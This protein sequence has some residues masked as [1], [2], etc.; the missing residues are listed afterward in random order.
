[1]TAFLDYIHEFHP[2]DLLLV[3]PVA[4][5]GWLFWKHRG[6]RFTFFE[7]LIGAVIASTFVTLV[8]TALIVGP[9]ALIGITAGLVAALYVPICLVVG[10]AT[11]AATRRYSRNSNA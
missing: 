8:V 4:L 6:S 7:T 11:L 2:Y 1:M 3:V 10:L 9:W 5:S